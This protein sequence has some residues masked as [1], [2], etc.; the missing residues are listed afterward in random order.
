MGRARADT[1]VVSPGEPDYLERRNGGRTVG[2]SRMSMSAFDKATENLV[3]WSARDEWMELQYEVYAAHF[4]PVAEVLDVPDDGLEDVIGEAA[5]MLGVFILEDFFT[6]RFGENGELNVV[7]DYLKRRGWRETAPGRRYLEALRDSTA[8]LYEVVGI[9]PGRSM[10]V[11]DLVLGGEAVTVREK[12]GSEAAAPWDRVAA[13]IVEVNGK[14]HFTGAILRF[15]HETS[16]HLLSTFDGMAKLLEQD[17]RQEARRRREEPPATL[18]EIREMMVFGQPGPQIITQFWLMDAILQAQASL[19]ELHNTDDEVIVFCEVRFP[20][21]G[22]EADVAAVLDGIEGFERDEEGEPAWTW[23]VP[24]SPL[25][26]MARRR[27]GDKAP[28]SGD[29]IGNTSLGHVEIEAGALMLFVNSRERSERG[30]DL[31]ASRLGDLVGSPLIS[32]QDPEAALE[33]QAD[34]GPEVPPEESVQAIHSIF[35]DYYRRALD[36]PH[37]MFD[38]KSP[39]QAAATKKGC[40]RVIDWLKQMENSE[41]RR[42]AQQ[43]HKPYDSSWMWRELGIE[44]PR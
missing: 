32:H 27:R 40:E 9:D 28:D 20:I 16:Q 41:H 38:G 25:H 42:A 11:R 34:A 35:D 14:M 2:R 33:E 6:A 24:G 43:G 1:R 4:D 13:R 12:L 8:S 37:S 3:R 39:R 44:G 10:A 7:D 15:R 36:D 31:L 26:R 23:S 17:I 22:G 21:T 5:G 29:D 18:A 19:P 30:R